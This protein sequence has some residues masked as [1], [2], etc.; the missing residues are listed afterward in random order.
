MSI[1]PAWFEQGHDVSSHSSLKTALKPGVTIM[2]TSKDKLRV[3]ARL[4]SK[5]AP[6][7]TWIREMKIPSAI[8]GGILSIIHPEQYRAGI[9]SLKKL[10]DFPEVVDNPNRLAEILS[11][12]SAPCHA[13]S[14]ISNRKTPRHRDIHGVRKWMDILL[15]V[16][17]YSQ[18]WLLL[19]GLGM[20]FDYT[21]GTVVGIP[22]CILTHV[23]ECNGDRAC[24][25][26]YMRE[27]VNERLLS[28]IGMWSSAELVL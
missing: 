25:A 4:S 2:Q 26:Y 3:S 5:D 10:H 23:A 12:W 17:E 21:P 6:A 14:V 15:A 8:I 1:S 24:I 22:G 9:E 11:V 20:K 18:G 27:N 13:I 19:N 7:S 28:Q 16:G